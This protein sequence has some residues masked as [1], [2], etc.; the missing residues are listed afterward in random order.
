MTLAEIQ[1]E[2]LDIKRELDRLEK[3]GAPQKEIAPLR[4]RIAAIETHLGIEKKIAA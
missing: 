4:D 1:E 2:L 3:R